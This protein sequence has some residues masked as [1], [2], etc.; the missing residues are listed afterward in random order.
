M[1][2]SQSI[3]PRT[4]T[5]SPFWREIPDISYD[6]Q[7]LF[8]WWRRHDGFG[9]K[10]VYNV[11]LNLYADLVERH[12]SYGLSAFKYWDGDVFSSLSYQQLHEMTEVL[13]LQW[14]QTLLLPG[15]TLLIASRS[16]LTRLVAL[17]AAFRAGLVATVIMPEGITR[18]IHQARHLDPDLIFADRDI[19]YL[20]PDDLNRRLL[21]VEGRSPVKLMGSYRYR[22]NDPAIRVLDP[23]H[24]DEQPKILSAS[25]LFIALIRDGCLV[26][27][28]G[29]GK[30][31]AGFPVLSGFSPF[32][33]LSVLLAG[34]ELVG[35]DSPL[36]N[37]TEVY[38]I[39]KK[40]AF[41]LVHLPREILASISELTFTDPPNWKRWFR[42]PVEAFDLMECSQQIGNI[43]AGQIP[44]AQILWSRQ[45]GS[46]ILGSVW[47]ED[48]TCLDLLPIPGTAWQLGDL[49]SPDKPSKSRLGRYCTIDES[50]DD[51]VYVPTPIMLTALGHA[52]RYVGTFPKGRRGVPFPSE[53]AIK[54]LEYPSTYH[55]VIEQ[56]SIDEAKAI[57]YILLA[58]METRPHSDL[59]N[60]LRSNVGED[61][62]PDEILIIP[63]FP[64]MAEDGMLDE[65]WIQRN[66]LSGELERR[67]GVPVYQKISA[68]KSA[69]QH[70]N[71]T[72]LQS[73]PITPGET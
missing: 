30:R 36:T 53:L 20:L 73:I 25:S 46:I 28:L 66:F 69:I 35:L 63:Q 12:S 4:S 51:V 2:T 10:S 38:K 29:K 62:V 33:E 13:L 64:R 19:G 48:F 72:L 22:P 14:S 54:T 55:V 56:P 50:D 52:Y 18:L 40:D 32:M 45:T 43:K 26:L 6:V 57:R 49:S 31:M 59:I 65:S 27:G 37:S 68:L 9:C 58:F 1:D 15:S 21:P 8:E 3:P 41:D 16:H 67:V 61:A 5:F 47:S 42:D 39:L 71:L 34:A 17:L 11:D 7:S 70:Y 24:P 60:L 23:Y 44:N